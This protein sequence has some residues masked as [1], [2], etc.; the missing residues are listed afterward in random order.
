MGT[1]EPAFWS[2]GNVLNL[3]L[4]GVHMCIFTK[5]YIDDLCTHYI[6]VILQ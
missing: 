1:R 6:F 2:P 3:D 5:L 4:H